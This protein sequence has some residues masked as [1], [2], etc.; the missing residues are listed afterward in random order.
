MLIEALDGLP[1]EEIVQLLTSFVQ[2]PVI[3]DPVPVTDSVTEAP[4][5]PAKV[6]E[7]PLVVEVV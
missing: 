5:D 3:V 4:V 6:C 2:L 7:G 1:P